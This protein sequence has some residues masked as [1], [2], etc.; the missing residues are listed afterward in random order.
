[1]TTLTY[2]LILSFVVIAIIIAFVV[3]FSLVSDLKREIKYLGQRVDSR[4]YE[5]SVQSISRIT[6]ETRD[7]LDA[8][9]THYNL[10]IEQEPEKY[11]VRKK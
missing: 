9:C 7:K 2:T 1:M 3:L 6:Y 5:S 11:V 8:V 4:A 10:E